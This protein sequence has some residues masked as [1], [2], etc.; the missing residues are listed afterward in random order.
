MPAVAR[1]VPDHIRKRTMAFRRK[2]GTRHDAGTAF[3]NQQKLLAL[4]MSELRVHSG[5]EVRNIE[6]WS[7]QVRQAR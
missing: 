4:T 2:P 7:Q 1:Q 5:K 3:V 6:A